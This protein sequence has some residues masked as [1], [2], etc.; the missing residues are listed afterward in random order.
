MHA[1]L[2]KG[3][4]ELLEESEGLRLA[5]GRWPASEDAKEVVLG[6]KTRTNLFKQPIRVGD[7]IVIKSKRLKVVGVI[8][9]IGEQV[10]DN[11][12]FISLKIFRELTGGGPVVRQGIVKTIP[13]SNLDLI[14]KQVRFQL[15]K[16][17]VV[18]DFA[19]FT[20]AKADRIIGDVLVIVELLL[21][22]IAFVSLVV[23]AVGIMNTMYTS[24][25]ERTK[26]IG[27]MKAVGASNE[28]IL[29]LFLLESGMIG[30]VGG[31]LGVLFG[32]TVAYVIGLAV[33]RLGIP[34]LF[35]FAALDYFG[36]LVVLMVT[37]V[38]G[39]IAGIFP[40]RQA[41]RMEPAEALRYE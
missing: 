16:Q 6:Y 19:V 33:A 12:I 11:S 2:W 14:A 39:I 36:F 15:S 3:M 17:E 10:H 23:G 22:A 30:F 25:L 34:G 29:F 26:Q 35:S 28:G 9:E 8:S 41:A 31:L 13:G 5:E 24:V 18:R 7:D 37:F 38:T 1:N 4:I 40:A 20:P 27:I 21:I 32:V